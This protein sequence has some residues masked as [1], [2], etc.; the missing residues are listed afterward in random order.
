[1]KHWILVL[2]MQWSTFSIHRPNLSPPNI[3][4]KS[5]TSTALARSLVT[6]V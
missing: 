4:D 6:A 3:D 5:G 1:L 2:L